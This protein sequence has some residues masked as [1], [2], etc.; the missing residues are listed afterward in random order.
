[1]PNTR[2]MSA[3]EFYELLCLCS[4]DFSKRF[5]NNNHQDFV[6][7]SKIHKIWLKEMLLLFLED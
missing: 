7:L 3:I 5:F 1:M 2:K 4:P 6:K